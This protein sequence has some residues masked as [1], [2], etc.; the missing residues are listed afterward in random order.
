MSS[1]VNQHTIL[2]V[3]S[4]PMQ[5]WLIVILVVYTFVQFLLPSVMGPLFT[6]NRGV[7]AYAKWLNVAGF[8][9]FAIAYLLNFGRI[10]TP[11]LEALRA[12]VII[13]LSVVLLALAVFLTGG[14]TDSPFAGAIALYIGFL[15]ILTR[16]QAYRSANMALIVITVLLLAAPYM[17]L[18]H[19]GY[20][21]LHILHWIDHPGV[22]W[23]RWGISIVLLLIAAVV[24]DKINERVKR[25]V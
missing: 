10:Q 16:K 23:S 3:I 19:Q 6:A 2:H 18:S 17:L 15:I 9:F 21:E 14:F 12:F 24:G 1:N 13:F 4:G 20:S 8:L 11:W 5:V 7:F 22:L 25:N